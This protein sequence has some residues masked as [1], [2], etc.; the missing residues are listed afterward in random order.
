MDN[1][2]LFWSMLAVLGALLTALAVAAQTQ[3]A[4]FRG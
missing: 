4:R 3:V 1:D 2:G